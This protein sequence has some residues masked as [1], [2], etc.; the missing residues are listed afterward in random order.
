MSDRYV[1]ANVV[2]QGYAGGL[3]VETLREIGRIATGDLMPDVTFVL[4]MPAA[5]AAARIDRQLDRMEQQGTEFH[6]R[7]RDGFLVEAARCPE[8][9]V[10]VDAARPIE[11]VQA[12]LRAAAEIAFYANGHIV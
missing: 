6:A 12:D 10:V 11:Q 1:L 7:V 5:A 4:D 2:Y 9:I 3:D 8:R